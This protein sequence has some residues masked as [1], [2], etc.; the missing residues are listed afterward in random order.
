MAR[1]I[2]RWIAKAMPLVEAGLPTHLRVGL[3]L[4][5]IVEVAVRPGRRGRIVLLPIMGLSI[6]GRIEIMTLLL[7]GGAVHA[8]VRIGLSEMLWQVVLS[9]LLHELVAEGG[10]SGWPSQLRQLRGCSQTSRL[11]PS[12]LRR[13]RG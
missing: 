12:Q 1:L 9:M 8:E 2:D 10:L 7:V 11:R 13:L 6:L 3:P 4:H 5:W